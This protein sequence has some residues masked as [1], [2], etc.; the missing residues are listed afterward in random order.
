MSVPIADLP[1]RIISEIYSRTADTLYEPIVVRGTF[2]L[3]A[4]DLESLIARQGKAAVSAAG[5][6]PIL[7]LPVGTAHFTLPFA[8]DH[9][10]LVVG[11]DIA[12]GMAAAAERHAEEQAVGNLR[13]VQADAHALPFATGS[14]RAIMCSNGL[15]VMPGLERTLM[16]LHRVLA[17]GG[18]MFVSVVN[19]PLGSI[20]PGVAS[21]H[22][23]TMFKSRAS[24]SSAIERVGFAIQGVATSR[25]ATLLEATKA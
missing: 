9:E 13:A 7:D 22:L 11:V 14:F 18:S 15:Q 10:G 3:A 21:E 2:R 5:G 4:N 8:R 16:E 19:F 24:M 23:P 25:L 6:G 20:L 12:H 17:R 1:K